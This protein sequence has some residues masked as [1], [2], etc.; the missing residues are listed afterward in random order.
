[1]F[2]LPEPYFDPGAPIVFDHASQSWPLSTY[3]DVSRLLTDRENFA[4]GTSLREIDPAFDAAALKALTP[5]AEAFAAQ[6]IDA[7][8]GDTFDIAPDLRRL[9][10][11]LAA[12]MGRPHAPLWQ[13]GLATATAA[14]GDCLL[15]LT[16][17]GHLPH[18]TQAPHTLAHAIDEVLRWHPPQP[19]IHRTTTGPVLVG[20][21]SLPPGAHVTGRVTAANRDPKRFPDPA[22]FDVTRDPN[23]HLSF[24]RGAHYCP[25]AALARLLC[26]VLL[27]QAATRMPTLRW[28]DHHPLRRDP[29]PIPYLTYAV[30]TTRPPTTKD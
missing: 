3:D 10:Q 14:L 26:A 16:H 9:P 18:V 28:D 5:P 7:W 13:A 12:H 20:Q 6:L 8:Q 4:A 11:Q 29:G 23:Q 2:A 15:F 24:G 27:Q 17:H 19:L 30:F 25:G 22:T 21:T 1:M